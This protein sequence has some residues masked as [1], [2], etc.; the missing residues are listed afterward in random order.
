MYIPNPDPVQYVGEP[1]PLIDQNWDTLTWGKLFKESIP[2][3][4]ILIVSGRYI[5]VT[6]DEAH[7]AWG[8]DIDE[9][10]DDQRGGYVAG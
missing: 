7:A 3:G 5:L 9:F 6:E 8:E 2:E 4:F 1:S 10:W